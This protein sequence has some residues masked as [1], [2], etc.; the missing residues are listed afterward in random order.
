MT[1]FEASEYGP[2][3]PQTPRDGTLRQRLGK[4][5]GFDQDPYTTMAVWKPILARSALVVDTGIDLEAS[6]TASIWST[7][8][9]AL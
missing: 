4:D 6:G 8:R 2:T 9:R 3:T 5:I 1:G 7:H